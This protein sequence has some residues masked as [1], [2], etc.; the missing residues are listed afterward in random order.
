VALDYG[1]ETTGISAIG[2]FSRSTN[3]VI[4]EYQ[5]TRSISAIAS[6]GFE[7]LDDRYYPLVVGQGGTWDVGGRWQPNIN[8]SILVVYGH[9]DLKT[10]IAG[11]V[12]FRLTPF[13]SFYAAYTDS[14]GTGQQ[15]LLAN[16]DASLLNPAGPV[17]GVTF[18][19]SSIIATL[20]DSSLAA[21]GDLDT[22][23]VPLGVP[24]ADV[25]N[26]TPLQNDLLR[27]KLFRA[28]LYSN[29]GASPISLTAYNADQT[30]LTFFGPPR[31]V[32]RGAYVS[33]TPSLSPD[34]YAFVQGGYN[35]NSLDKGNLYSASVGA[36]YGLSP[37]IALGMRY[38]FA[39]RTARPYTGGYIQNAV[40]VSINKNF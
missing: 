24:L 33:W 13:T 4:Q 14:I 30:S 34:L 28:T 18:D 9:H 8:S 11:E 36:H 23:G 1:S 15:S 20:N 7:W 16:N 40:T 25:E 3:S 39:Y 21:A 12:Q 5:I 2:T 6:G 17:S 10:D 26:F 19:Q 32:T 22:T 31:T 29:I 37:T 27:T 35:S 38:D